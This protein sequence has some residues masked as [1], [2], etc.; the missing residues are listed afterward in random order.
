MQNHVRRVS[1]S[2]LGSELTVTQASG[3]RRT[4]AL[5]FDSTR[6]VNSRRRVSSQSTYGCR[7]RL[8]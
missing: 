6:I 7:F 5:H 4:V 3:S 1:R 8:P 2:L